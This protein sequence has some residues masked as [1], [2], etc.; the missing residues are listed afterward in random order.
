MREEIKRTILKVAGKY[1]VKVEKIILFGSR[2]RGD[3]REDSDWDV[4]IVTERKIDENIKYKLL[5]EIRRSIVWRFDVPV[6][7]IIV[8]REYME[9]YKDVYGS[10]VGMAMLEGSII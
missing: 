8:D 4:L 2:A 6:D 9:S 1:G 7:V 10:I 3:Y 5:H